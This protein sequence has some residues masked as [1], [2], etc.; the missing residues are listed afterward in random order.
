MI[1]TEDLRLQIIELYDECVENTNQFHR[2]LDLFQ[3]P[4]TLAIII[5]KATGINIEGY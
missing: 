1:D 5:S 4:D 3:I 2:K